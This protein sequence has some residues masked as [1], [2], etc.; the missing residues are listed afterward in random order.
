VLRISNREPRLRPC[1]FPCFPV[2][3]APNLFPGLPSISHIGRSHP[4]H[5]PVNAKYDQNG[6]TVIAVTEYLLNPRYPEHDFQVH[7]RRAQVNQQ[8]TGQAR[9]HSRAESISSTNLPPSRKVRN[10]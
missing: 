6:P 3:L 10:E 4:P 8:K 9:R 7:V 5:R 1:P 2:G